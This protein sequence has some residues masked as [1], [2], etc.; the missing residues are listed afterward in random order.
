ME[1][2]GQEGPG[3]YIHPPFFSQRSE[4]RKKIIPILVLEKYLPLLDAPPHY[5]VQNSWRI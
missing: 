1:M 5:M 3:I 2:I 4:A